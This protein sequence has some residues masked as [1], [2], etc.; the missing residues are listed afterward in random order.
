M[1]LILPPWVLDGKCL[2]R[3]ATTHGQCESLW[4][5]GV[6]P[7]MVIPSS[8]F[9]SFQDPKERLKVHAEGME[10]CLQNCIRE[11]RGSTEVTTVPLQ[12][13]TSVF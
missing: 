13:K 3:N 12:G 4:P 7:A 11:T 8:A 9:G 10:Y 1:K 2:Q 5:V 6:F